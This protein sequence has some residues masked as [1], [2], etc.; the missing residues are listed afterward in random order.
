MTRILIR[1]EAAPRV[2]VFSFQTM[3]KV[4]LIFGS[5]TRVINPYMGWVLGEF[6]DQMAQ[7]LTVWLPWRRNDRK[8]E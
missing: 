7:R 8:W 2:S 4:V 1:E 3:V 5:E 6:Q